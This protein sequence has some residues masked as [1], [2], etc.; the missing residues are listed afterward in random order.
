RARDPDRDVLRG[1]HLSAQSVTAHQQQ[2]DGGRSVRSAG[3]DCGWYDQCGL[4]DSV[5]RR[6]ATLLG[7]NMKRSKSIELVLIGTMPLRLTACGDG[8]APPPPAPQS[9]LAY[10]NLQQCVSEGKVSAD[11]CEKAY[12]DAV[13][14]QYRSGPHYNT[15]NE[16]EAQYGWNQCHEVHTS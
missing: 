2:R 6:Q 7:G 11:I 13:D 15:Q 4:H 14:A 12:A 9:T 8:N 1:A 3:V 5:S 10:Q 16:C